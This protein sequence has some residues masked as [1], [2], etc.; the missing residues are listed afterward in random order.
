MTTTIVGNLTNDPELKFT[1]SGAAV[2]NFT[3]AVSKR[4]KEGDKWVDGPS[5]FYRCSIWRQYAENIAESL[6][7]GTRVIVTGEMHQRE[8]EDK[9]GEKRSV[10]EL[11]ADEVGVILRYATA[12]VTRVERART[13]VDAIPTPADDPWTTPAPAGEM[14]F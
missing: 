8:Y 3:V 14:P 7:K 5:S 10:W 9:Q 12:R 11:H 13:G 6:S 1:P 4:V 2:A